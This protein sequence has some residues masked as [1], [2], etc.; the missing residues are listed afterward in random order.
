M[1]TISVVENQAHLSVA[2]R[3]VFCSSVFRAVWLVRWW[4]EVL[5]DTLGIF[6][7]HLR[8]SLLFEQKETSC[9]LGKI[10]P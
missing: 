3:A 5:L 7:S 2:S 10:L 1:A 4:I 9:H 6:S 8:W